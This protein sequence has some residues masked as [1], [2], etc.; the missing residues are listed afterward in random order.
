[1]GNSLNNATTFNLKPIGNPY[2]MLLPGVI[3]LVIF[4]LLPL[5]LMLVMS[6]WTSSVFGTKPAFEI[7]NF[8]RQIENPLYSVLLFKTLRIALVSVL[9]ALVLS[10]PLA[11]FLTRLKGRM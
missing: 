7:A 6:F 3:W 2:L 4:A 8:A 11:Y 10:Y 1:M 9:I 5:V